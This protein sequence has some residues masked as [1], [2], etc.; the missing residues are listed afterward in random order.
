MG[1]GRRLT[2]VN[3]LPWLLR[4]TEHTRTDPGQWM[5]SM[6]KQAPTPLSSLS[7]AN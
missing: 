4:L 1:W 2:F 7:G 3:V 6:N 5:I